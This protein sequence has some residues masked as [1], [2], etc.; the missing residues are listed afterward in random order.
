MGTRPSRTCSGRARQKGRSWKVEGCSL[1]RSEPRGDDN[2]GTGFGRL[3]SLLISPRTNAGAGRLE[4]A[5]ERLA[6][7]TEAD[8]RIFNNAQAPGATNAAG[9]V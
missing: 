5:R 3:G 7:A 6:P 9:I 1:G 2:S 4:R 8:A